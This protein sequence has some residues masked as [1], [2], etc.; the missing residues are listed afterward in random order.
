MCVV[1][2]TGKGDKTGRGKRAAELYARAGVLEGVCA[3]FLV[4]EGRGSKVNFITPLLGVEPR[5]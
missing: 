4:R 5:S 1:V 3:P 2:T